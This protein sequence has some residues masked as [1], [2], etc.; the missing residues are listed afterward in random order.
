ME[1]INTLWNSL[2]Q[3]AMT[4]GLKILGAIVILLVGFWLARVVKRYTLRALG[5]MEVD[6]ALRK[7]SGSLAYYGVLVV[8]IIGALN[9]LGIATASLVAVLGA[10]ALAIGLALE[11]ALSNLA[12]GVLL[13]FFRPFK[14]HDLVE[15]AGYTGH[16]EE[17][18]I[19]STILVTL[20]NKT[21]TIPNSQVTGSPIVNYTQRGLVRLDMVFG[22]GYGDDLAKAKAVLEDILVNEERVA[23]D[24]APLV[25]VDALA[26]SSVN[27]AVRPFVD[28]EDYW[29]VYFA[30]TEQVKL[31]FDAEGISI[32]FPQRDVHLMQAS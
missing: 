22:I 14:I 1:T 9:T 8:V 21:V 24:P 32:P 13:L 4:Y 12:A 25:A 26:D 11:G 5:R 6:E 3:L 16:V 17:I 29:G 23:T 20:D 28:P 31:R 2:V 15:I 10:G 27:F 7:F 30:I 18:M 19:F